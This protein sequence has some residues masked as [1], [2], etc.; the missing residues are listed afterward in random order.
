[1][2]IVW[3]PLALAK[4]QEI[5]AYIALDKPMAA[6]RWANSVFEIVENL[7]AS[8]KL[9]RVVPEA[10]R[11]DIR[12]LLHGSYRIMYRVEDDAISILTIRRGSRLFDPREIEQ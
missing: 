5:T 4:V 1:M 10:H 8:P 12:E 3:T 11:E 2:K 7:E 6:E 9:G